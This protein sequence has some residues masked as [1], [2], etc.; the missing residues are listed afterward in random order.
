M[1][2]GPISR[3]A[4]LTIRA[5][6]RGARASAERALEL[7]DP[8]REPQELPFEPI[9]GGIVTLLAYDAPRFMGLP[10]AATQQSW[11]ISLGKALAQ[12]VANLE[13]MSEP[14]S[15]S[16]VWLGDREPQLPGG[17]RHDAQVTLFLLRR[18]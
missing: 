9:V 15:M 1:P 7:L 8:A 10:T 17:R 2:R 18:I 14:R 4:D 3:A 13:R 6:I 5:A 11:G 12:A 16:C